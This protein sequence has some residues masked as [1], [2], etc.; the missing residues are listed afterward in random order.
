M[1]LFRMLGVAAQAEG[2]RL[3][4]EVRGTA[5]QAGWIA[6]ASVFGLAAIAT[7]HVAAVAYLTPSFGIAGAA[8]MVAAGDLAI[9]AALA[10]C[11][12]RRR[13]PVAEEARLL[14]E[15]MLN[16]VTARSPLRDA[17]GLALRSGSGPLIGAAAGEAL[18][19]WLRRR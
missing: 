11:A 9:A 19:A 12:R 6:A 16:A 5:L 17:L 18:A 3:R 15:T 13:D 7:A 1:R 14:R 8:A 10:L 2:I 4:R